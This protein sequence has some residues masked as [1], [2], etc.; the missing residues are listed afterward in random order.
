MFVFMLGLLVEEKAMR[1]LKKILSIRLETS[2]IALIF[3][4]SW[5]FMLRKHPPQSSGEWAAWMEVWG[6][7]VAIFVSALLF[8]RQRQ[9]EV[10][11]AADEALL[12]RYRTV[13]AVQ[14]VTFWALEVMRQGLEHM[15]TDGAYGTLA[16]GSERFDQVRDL[17]ERFVDPAVDNVCL[18]TALIT[19]HKIAE[20][21]SDFFAVRDSVL[22]DHSIQK[23][24]QRIRE[25]EETHQ[26]LIN[27][28]IELQQKCKMLGLIE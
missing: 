17:V 24:I 10:K 8:H 25:I 5:V 14:S 23:C 9:V 21:K 20:F 13:Q 6:T 1:F 2:G 19:S 11:K 12:S 28:Q 7:M 16:F 3:L 18:Q 22:R 15:E 26:R 4:I 27:M